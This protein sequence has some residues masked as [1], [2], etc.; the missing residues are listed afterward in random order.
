MSKV[1]YGKVAL[2][3]QGQLNQLKSRG[4]IIENEAK[5][6]HILKNVSYYRLSGYWYPFLE[7]KQNHIFKSNASFDKAFKLYCFDRELRKLVSAEIEKVEVAIRAHMIY[8]LSHAYG[9]FWYTDAS[10][11]SNTF[12]HTKSIQSLVTEF[13]RSDEQ[14]IKA[15]KDKYSDPLPPSWIMFEITSF[16]VLSKL[17]DNLRPIPEKRIIANIFGLD[18]KTFAS[19]IHSIVYVRNVCAHHTRLWNRV[20]RIQPRI[21]RNPHNQWLNNSTLV[22]NRLFMVVSM[23]LYL[24]NTVNPHNKFKL[25]IRNILSKYPD[26]DTFAMGFPSNWEAE[27]IWQL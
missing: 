22:N 10:L 27:L 6:L 11:F 8:V 12:S 13:N 26:I 25:K 14:F 16:G 20:M 5:A 4:L 19:W 18:E 2:S 17:F 9:A 3:Y 21:P 7:D 24:L 1:P 23:I 15:F